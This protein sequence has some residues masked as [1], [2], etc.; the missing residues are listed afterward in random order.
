MYHFNSTYTRQLLILCELLNIPFLIQMA[1]KKTKDHLFAGLLHSP[2]S[3][4]LDHVFAVGAGLAVAAH[5]GLA[6]LTT[7]SS[8]AIP[9]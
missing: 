2:R 8:T 6:I 9:C 5:A 1:L 4:V 7:D 3:S